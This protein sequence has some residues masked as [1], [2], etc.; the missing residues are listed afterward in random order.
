[1]A[2]YGFAFFDSGVRFD[3]PD[4]HPSASMIDLHRFLKNPFDSKEVS[5][6]ELIAFSTDH[7]QRMI[8]NNPGGA[9]TSRITATSSALDLVEDCATDDQTKLGLRK[10]R[11]MAKG[12][13]RA[14]LAPQVAQIVAAVEA[15]YGVGAAEV[16]ECVPQGRSVFSACRDD[17]LTIH[18]ETLV[19]GLTA[20][21]ADLGA[22]LVATAQALLD[23]WDVVYSASETSTGAKTTTEEEKQLARENLQLMLFLNLLK[24]AEMF[25]RQPDQLDLY[26][27]QSLLENPQEAEE[28]P[29]PP[30]GP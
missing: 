23:A 10:A 15:K 27:Q 5:L 18:L 7:L 6:A 16:V 11:K 19:A 22:P 29:P 21:V 20:H 12:A 3:A 24:L 26:M 13:F 2:R 25:A 30:P 1:M 28:E 8:A 17:Q 4:A 9:L 14:D